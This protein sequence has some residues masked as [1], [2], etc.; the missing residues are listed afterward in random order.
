MRRFRSTRKEVNRPDGLSLRVFKEVLDTRSRVELRLRDL[1]EK[2][3]ELEEE[4]AA[5]KE[6][7]EKKAH[8]EL[9]EQKDQ[10]GRPCADDSAW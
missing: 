3:E 7:E 8:S 9:K 10:F 6:A 2:L 4:L 5:A 1:E